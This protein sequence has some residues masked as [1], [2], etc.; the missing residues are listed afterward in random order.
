VDG[1]VRATATQVNWRR[2]IS[3]VQDGSAPERRG[4]RRIECGSVSPASR[5]TR[6]RDKLEIDC[7]SHSNIVWNRGS[8]GH[9]G[10]GFRTDC[11]TEGDLESSA[12]YL[13][14]L[15]KMRR[16]KTASASKRG[17]SW[18][19]SMAGC[20]A[21]SIFVGR[22]SHLRC[23]ALHKA[24]DN[25]G[26]RSLSLFETSA[27]SAGEAQ[28]RPRQLRGPTP[29]SAGASARLANKHSSNQHVKD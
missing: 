20:L 10:L 18:R 8:A 23:D 27:G 16:R 25:V 19:I 4:Q 28:R 15:P 22:G 3:P 21:G 14:R 13:R 1:A 12:G 5:P 6:G 17:S 2:D 7:R 29:T 9:P 26:V 11:R 24:R